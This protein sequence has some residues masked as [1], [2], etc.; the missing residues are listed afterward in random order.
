VFGVEYVVDLV[1]RERKVT[2]LGVV[3]D[4]RMTINSNLEHLRESA[5]KGVSILK[6]AAATNSTHASMHK[7]E[8][9]LNKSA[10]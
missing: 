5:L 8:T 1:C 2:G 6:Y 9:L 10:H 3:L 7:R 4:Y